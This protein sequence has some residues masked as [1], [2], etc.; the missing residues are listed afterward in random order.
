MHVDSGDG[1]VYVNDSA[2]RW[3]RYVDDKLFI[4]ELE[5]VV[6][7]D[8]DGHYFLRSPLS[9]VSWDSMEPIFEARGAL[10]VV[11]HKGASGAAA[12]LGG[13]LGAL[14]AGTVEVF[15]VEQ[16]VESE[17]GAGQAIEGEASVGSLGRE[18]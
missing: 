4:R 5:G 12:A 10:R 15:Q 16:S 13:L 1:A 17:V 6:H 8:E 2:V 18:G 7:V 14:C 3:M 11:Y 9:F